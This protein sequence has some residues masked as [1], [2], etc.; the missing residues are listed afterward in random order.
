MPWIPQYRVLSDGAP[1]GSSCT[2]CVSVGWAAEDGTVAVMVD[3]E[4]G[5]TAVSMTQSSSLAGTGAAV[6]VVA[7]KLKVEPSSQDGRAAS[8]SEEAGVVTG[9]GTKETVEVVGDDGAGEGVT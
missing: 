6:V 5:R 1:V 2:H 7:K 3:V 9:S 8:V 4:T